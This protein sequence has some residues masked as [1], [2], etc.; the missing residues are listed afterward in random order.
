MF[1]IGV[2]NA[3]R[4]H[5]KTSNQP[6]YFYQFCLESKLNMFKQM[7]K[8][9]V[10]GKKK[11]T[12]NRDK[13]IDALIKFTGAG[14]VDDLGYLFKTKYTPENLKGTIEESYM[15]K[16]TKLWINYATYGNPNGAEVSVW[17]SIENDHFYYL[18]IAE[19]IECRKNPNEARMLFWDNLIDSV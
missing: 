18:N 7:M 17:K 15:K 5:A 10:A 3:A 14:H 1:N 11:K 9:D 4:L 13:L 6:I 12:I 16:V 2:Y 8:I 19:E